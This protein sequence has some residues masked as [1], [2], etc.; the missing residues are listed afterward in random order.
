MYMYLVIHV[1]AKNSRRQND[2]KLL[3]KTEK[4]GIHMK[5]KDYH[6]ISFKML[7]YFLK[8]MYMFIV[9]KNVLHLLL[10]YICRRQSFCL[11]N[12]FLEE[13]EEEVYLLVSLSDYWIHSIIN[14]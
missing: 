10:W 11:L 13:E 7:L 8:H 5:G 9:G 6:T 14:D 12:M 1:S 2:N 4:K 3:H